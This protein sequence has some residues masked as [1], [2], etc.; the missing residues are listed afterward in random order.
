VSL[1][2]VAELAERLGGPR[3]PIVLDVR[4]PIHGPADRKGFLQGHIPGARFV[5]LDT[6]LSAPEGGAKGGGHPL[7]SATAFT[8][9]MRA[10][11]VRKSRPVVVHDLSD[12]L[13]AS[14]AWWCLR[15]FG[16]PDVR[17]LDGGFTAWRAARLPV[18]E[19]EPEPVEPG[20]FRAKAGHLPVLDADAA[21]AL[22]KRGL[23][24][25]VRSAARYRGEDPVDLVRGHV[26]GAVSA[27]TIE[28]VDGSGNWLP[29]RELTDRYRSLGVSRK[30]VGVYCGSGVTACHTA[31]AMT[32]VGLPT[33]ALYVGSWSEWSAQGR[34]VGI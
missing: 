4:W 17:L 23:L 29:V 16:H 18:A 21:A 13:A 5:D 22:P 8:A 3:P 20:N 27:P 25:D 9:A 28:N 10:H 1:I 11:G 14:R 24:L 6:E 31:L 7:P 32:E 12:G 30:P 2:S 19:G 15:Y 33:P 26:P 34:P